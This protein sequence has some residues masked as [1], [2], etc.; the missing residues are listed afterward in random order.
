MTEYWNE[1]SVAIFRVHIF[2]F[3]KSML[4][5][6]KLLI[7]LSCSF[8]YRDL[9]CLAKYLQMVT[10]TSAI[11]RLSRCC[12]C[13]FFKKTGAISTQIKRWQIEL[14]YRYESKPAIVLNIQK[15]Y[16]N[17]ILFTFCIYCEWS[18]PMD[19]GYFSLTKT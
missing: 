18:P 7:L 17:Y 11:G 2:I 4:G 13:W 14:L 3:P 1:K 12:A 16:K 8:F 6:R 5:K 9:L 19:L 15:L 10:C